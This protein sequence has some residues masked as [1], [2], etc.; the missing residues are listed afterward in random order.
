MQ[1]E[2]QSI[3]L[4]G[5]QG[6]MTELV[7]KGRI[8]HFTANDKDRNSN[9]WTDYSILIWGGGGGGVDNTLTACISQADW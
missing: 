5:R 3:I 1:L 4:D 6:F 2:D 7:K 8:A 9:A